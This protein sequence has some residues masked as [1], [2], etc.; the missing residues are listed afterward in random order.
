MKSF[1][2][3]VW[4]GSQKT[5]LVLQAHNT[6][7]AISIAKKVYPSGRVISAREIK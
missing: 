4:F 6:A 1:Q 3:Q 2:V 7:Q 5:N